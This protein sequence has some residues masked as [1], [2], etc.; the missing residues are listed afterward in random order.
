[1]KRIFII[2]TVLLT[3]LFIDGCASEKLTGRATVSGRTIE[4]TLNKSDR[5]ISTILHKE[6][7]PNGVLVFYVPGFSDTDAKSKLALEYLRRMP[8][9]WEM[10]YQGG[11]YSTGGE[12]AIYFQF[13]PDDGDKNTPLPLFYG[14][15]KE[16][17]VAQVSVIDL[18]TQIQEQAKIITVDRKPGLT[19]DLRVWYA[20]ME[21][22]A[23]IFEI[24]GKSATGEVLFSQKVGFPT[25]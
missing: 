17:E 5:N 15:I 13:L 3:I 2:I 10:S 18:G 12:Q 7:L 11:M 16:R 14:E 19:D 20:A 6:E 23:S 22:Q 9:G 25:C 8:Y 1:M 21:P 4:E 24:V